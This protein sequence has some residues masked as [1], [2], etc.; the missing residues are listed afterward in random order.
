MIVSIVVASVV[1]WAMVSE[2]D[3]SLGLGT[4]IAE[5]TIVRIDFGLAAR[6]VVRSEEGVVG[7]RSLR[8]TVKKAKIGAVTHSRS[9]LRS[10]H[11]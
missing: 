8:R 4:L 1:S 9:S 7:S 6:V 10:L 5:E 11:F 2:V 3:V